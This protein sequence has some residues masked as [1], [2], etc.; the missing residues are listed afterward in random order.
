MSKIYAIDFD[1]TLCQEAFPQIGEANQRMISYVKYLH[2]NG[3]KLILWTCRNGDRLQEAVSWCDAHGITFDAVN[4]NLPET[5]ALY[6]TNSRK[7]TADYY[8]DDKAQSLFIFNLRLRIFNRIGGLL[9][10]RLSIS[11]FS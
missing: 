2:N 3:N 4:D 9:C 11:P 10:S 8:I 5:L 1:G 6:G 7:I